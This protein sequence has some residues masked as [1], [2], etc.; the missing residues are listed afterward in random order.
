MVVIY[1]FQLLE[2]CCSSPEMVTSL[3]ITSCKLARSKQ[4]VN[5]IFKVLR[6]RQSE[7]GRF[8]LFLRK[9]DGYSHSQLSSRRPCGVRSMKT[10]K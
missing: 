7:G 1:S 9:D 8:D 3:D 2:I 6:Q 10:D 5:C 4:G